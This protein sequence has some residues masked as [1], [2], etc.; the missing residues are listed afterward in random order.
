MFCPRCH[1][2]FVAE[3]TVCPDCGVP[4][5]EQL[6]SSRPAP[7]DT[8]PALAP[9]HWR[10]A[11]VGTR[12]HGS[13]FAGGAAWKVP[14][15]IVVL[16]IVVVR[17]LFARGD[18]GNTVFGVVLSGVGLLLLLLWRGWL[19]RPVDPDSQRAV[20]RYVAT[21]EWGVSTRR[22]H[23]AENAYVERLWPK[24]PRRP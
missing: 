23:Q 1:D 20:D 6:R 18:A 19:R 4:L 9:F 5:R 7:R 14:I 13:G 12:R 2:E 15:A 11:R 24:R 17:P 22:R 3:L 21:G 10:W 16:T 8:R